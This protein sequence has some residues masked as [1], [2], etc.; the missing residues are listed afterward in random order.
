MLA[1]FVCQS[2]T[3]LKTILKKHEKIRNLFLKAALEQRHQTLALYSS[4]DTNTRQFHSF[5]E[6]LYDDYRHLCS[7]YKVDV[8]PFSKIERFNSLVMSHQAE[9]W[10]INNSQSIIKNYAAEY[11]NLMGKDDSLTVGVIMEASAQMHRFALGIMEME[12]YLTYNKS[13][14][15][16]DSR[17]DLFTLLFELSINVYYKLYDIEPIK[18]DINLIIKVADRL[19]I[20]NKK[21]LELRSNEFK[22]YNYDED[23][24]EKTVF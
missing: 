2:S 11:I 21:M 10:E 14:L 13:I 12:S 23:L 16:C 5:V 9:E 15:L 18:K 20:Y 4:L 17:N 1:S 24:S 7:T 22:N 8:A 6:S 3:D 19:N